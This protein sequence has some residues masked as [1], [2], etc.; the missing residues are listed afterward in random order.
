[1]SSIFATLSTYLNTPSSK[2]LAVDILPSSY[3]LPAPYPDPPILYEESDTDFS[4][5]I[6][7]KDLAQ[8]FLE[9][10]KILLT[11]HEHPSGHDSSESTTEDDLS[12]SYRHDKVYHATSVILLF[13]PEHITAANYRKRFLVARLSS[14]AASAMESTSFTEVIKRELDLLNTLLTSHLKRHTKSPTLWSHRLW[15][16]RTFLVTDAMLIQERRRLLERELEV[17][18]KAA[19][20]H[21][22]NYY[23]FMHARHVLWLITG[24]REGTELQ[25]V[26]KMSFVGQQVWH[27]VK[28]WC[29]SHPRDISGWNFLVFLLQRLEDDDRLSRELEKEVREFVENVRWEGENIS[30]LL[31]ALN[32]LEETRAKGAITA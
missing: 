3:P 11:L 9:A 28:N 20:H 16:L 19:D 5:A 15:L 17:V 1:M 22:A 29:F 4:L 2:P 31:K 32:H 12:R 14:A 10:R 26:V 21:F 6:R 24:V 13:D 8:A 25:G 18:L 27:N 23:A 7:K 30:W